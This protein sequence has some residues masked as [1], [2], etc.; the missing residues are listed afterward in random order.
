MCNP[1][2]AVA[3]AAGVGSSLYGSKLQQDAYNK[4]DAAQADAIR[5]SNA[6]ALAL[7]GAERAR[8]QGFTQ[9]STAAFNDSLKNNSAD[10]QAAQ[11]ATIR[12]GLANQ[13]GATADKAADYSNIPGIST[14]A[15]SGDENKVV[16]DSYKRA[17]G[18]VKNFLGQQAGSKAAL[19]A[20]GNL[21]QQQNTAN[22]R[23]LQNQGI[24]GNFMQ[25]SSNVLANELAA[26]KEASDLAYANA[27]N[28][29]NGLLNQAALF[30]GLGQIGTSIGAQGLGGAAAGGAAGS[31][32]KGLMSLFAT[33]KP[34]VTGF[35]NG[36]TFTSTPYF[37]PG[38]F[39]LN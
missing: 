29:G 16:A 22:A 20:Y 15:A 30:S 35:G 8:Q 25:G 6:A 31:G 39:G 18:N 37:T 10:S 24:L 33:Q 14:P 27:Q 5:K 19:D 13:Y 21:S 4:V 2:A 7:Q 3:L 12:E 11:E 32:G 1:L 9:Q 38:K 26:N 28:A 36:A 17:F 34:T 23:Q